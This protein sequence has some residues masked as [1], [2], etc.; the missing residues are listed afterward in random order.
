MRI[1]SFFLSA[2]VDFF[3]VGFVAGEFDAPEEYLDVFGLIHTIVVHGVAVG[4][5]FAFRIPIAH[6]Q[7]CDTHELGNLLHHEIFFRH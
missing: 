1:G 6:R 7:G 2:D 4:D 3:G 5:Q